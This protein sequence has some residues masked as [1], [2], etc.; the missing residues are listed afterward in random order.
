MGRIPFSA[1]LNYYN[2]TVRSFFAGTE[3]L[4]TCMNVL[5]FALYMILLFTGHRRANTLPCTFT[6]RRWRTSSAGTAAPSWFGSV[7]LRRTKP[8]M[9]P[10]SGFI[11]TVALFWSR[12]GPRSG[13]S[14]A[15]AFPLSNWLPQPV[16]AWKFWRVSAS[17][18]PV[19]TT[20]DG[21][22]FIWAGLSPV[23][24]DPATSG[25]SHRQD[26]WRT[27]QRPELPSVFLCK[28]VK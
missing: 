25:P 12:R 1:Y 9:P 14:P 26:H 19:C 11:R 21:W 10:A 18:G 7:A 27:A 22:R 20:M 2:Q 24:V 8:S 4:L 23:E 5:L 16:C 15:R 13:W 3:S 28:F 17:V 6:G